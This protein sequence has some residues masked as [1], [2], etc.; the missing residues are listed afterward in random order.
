MPAVSETSLGS[1]AKAKN[2]L[3]Q[4]NL[5][6]QKQETGFLQETRFLDLRVKETWVL[7]LVLVVAGRW[8][9]LIPTARDATATDGERW[10]AESPLVTGVF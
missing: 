1:Q 10:A 5:E 2:R 9:L 6:R 8:Q 4:R 7:A 3:Y